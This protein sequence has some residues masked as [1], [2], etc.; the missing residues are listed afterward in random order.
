MV[1]LICLNMPKYLLLFWNEINFDFR[2]LGS[3]DFFRCPF[4]S[5]V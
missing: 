1:V 2:S 4:P 5:G 3:D